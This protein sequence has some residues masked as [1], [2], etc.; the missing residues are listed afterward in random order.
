M[1]REIILNALFYYAKYF[2][3]FYE[4]TRQPSNGWPPRGGLSIITQAINAIAAS[5]PAQ[6]SAMR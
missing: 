4:N 3:Q 6:L 5:K 2:L 1:S